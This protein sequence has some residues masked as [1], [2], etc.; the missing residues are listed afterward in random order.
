M[1]LLVI[2][3]TS[4]V[5]AGF[6]GVVVFSNF[7]L[8]YVYIVLLHYPFRYVV[9]TSL[10]AGLAYDVLTIGKLGQT[11]LIFLILVGAVKFLRSSVD[12]SGSGSL[13]SDLLMFL[14][15]AIVDSVMSGN[16][17]R[18]VYDMVICFVFCE[19][20][21]YFSYRAGDIKIRRVV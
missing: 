19:I 14:P 8:V 13:L 3:I 10:L 2:L 18:F 12:S 20:A 5:L 16:L 4:L 21:R 6:Q 17:L 1:S 11:T 7:L 15:I 9:L